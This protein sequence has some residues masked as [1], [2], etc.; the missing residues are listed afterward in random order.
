MGVDQGNL[1]KSIEDVLDETEKEESF[2]EFLIRKG[3]CSVPQI[4]AANF[5]R[6]VTGR[7]L[8][9]TLKQ[10][11]YLS[12]K[13]TLVAM[14]SYNA[15]SLSYLTSWDIAVPK[16]LLKEHNI[17]INAVQE[18]HV[19]VSSTEPERLVRDIVSYYYPNKEVRFVAF[20]VAQFEEFLEKL[21][22]PIEDV[23]VGGLTGSLEAE[24]IVKDIEEDN[25]ILTNL[26]RRC[27]IFGGS[28]IHIEPKSETYL[29]KVR[30]NG[31]LVQIHE[32]SKDQH[33]VLVAQLKDK[34]SI[35]MMEER[36]DQDGSFREIVG[37]NT[38]DYRV[39]L[40]P[41]GHGQKEV[42][43]ILDPE[44]STKKLNE[45]GMSED[46]Y[47]RM[48]RLLERPKGL[49]LI[50][51]TTGSGKSTTLEA[52]YGEID[53]LGKAIYAAEAPVEY[54]T[55]NISKTSKNDL[56]GMTMGRITRSYMRGDPDV[57]S[58]GEVRDEE[59]AR[60]IVDSAETGHLTMG[61]LH[62]G[63]AAEAHQ[64]LVGKGVEE[65]ALESAL[66]GVLYQRLFK[67]TCQ[68]CLGKGCA[69][70]FNTGYGGRLV[71][72]E[73]A[74]F[75][76]REEVRR[77]ASGETWWPSLLDDG[78]EK[79]GRGYTDEKE[80][81]RVF[82][83]ELRTERANRSELEAIRLHLVSVMDGERPVREAFECEALKQVG[84]TG[85]YSKVK[86]AQRI[87]KEGQAA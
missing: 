29:V 77:M 31:E 71:F 35:D 9:D 1:A 18:D 50:I 36:V 46:V 23:I 42:I 24:S 38:V 44:N 65:L 87:R 4:R 40:I 12:D 45:L 74:S 11:R 68:H 56:V 60:G 41:I 5:E 54:H 27:T 7:S 3:F 43:R 83:D 34:A 48:Q 79:F 75:N 67:T 57:I 32:G 6:G 16:E 19:T 25:E 84:A 47:A 51:G 20:R 72:A 10:N 30:Y 80:M 2:S 15:G 17:L 64:R 63:S 8:V 61:T 85:K 22:Q 58:V 39:V 28:D 53:S 49:I 66:C 37:D 81:E 14:E 13:D 76:T 52:S 78:L 69:A 70:C 33:K 73:L 21:E 55:T 59:T 86:A 82:G 26:L 62:S